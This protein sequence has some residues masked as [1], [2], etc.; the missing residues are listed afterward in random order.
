MSFARECL[1]VGRQV[2]AAGE[3][4]QGRVVSERER[5]ADEDLGQQ[6]DA[7]RQLERQQVI[8]IERQVWAMLLKNRAAGQ[9]HGGGPGERRLGVHP[10]E[11]FQER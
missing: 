7:P 3:A 10:R 1:G 6:R 5:R 9:E 8:R 11:V 4:H 2:R